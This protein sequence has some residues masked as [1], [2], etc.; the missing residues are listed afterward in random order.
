M[1]AALAGMYDASAAA[2]TRA[3]T[4]QECAAAQQNV[5]F[6]C[7]EAALCWHKLVAAL[8]TLDLKRA[9]NNVTGA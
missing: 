7:H 8:G 6:S 1:G 2:A 3:G 4:A 9:A 5:S